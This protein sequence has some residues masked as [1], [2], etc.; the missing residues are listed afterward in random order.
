VGFEDRLLGMGA[1]YATAGR[2]AT[3]DEDGARLAS[4]AAKQAGQRTMESLRAAGRSVEASS[5]Q[6]SPPAEVQ[7]ALQL[8]PGAD[9]ERIA[10]QPVVQSPGTSFQTKPPSTPDSTAPPKA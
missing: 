7:V 4:R 3:E 8:L 10:S 9:R 1:E 5:I 6:C 2:R